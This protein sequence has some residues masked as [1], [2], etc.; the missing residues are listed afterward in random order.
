MT[1][2]KDRL[3][4]LERMGALGWAASINNP[5]PVDQEQSPKLKFISLND[6]AVDDALHFATTAIL[7][8]QSD[9]WEKAYFSG[10]STDDARTAALA[11]IEAQQIAYQLMNIRSANMDGV[12]IQGTPLK[13]EFKTVKEIKD[14]N[15]AGVGTPGFTPYPIADTSVDD[16]PYIILT[17]PPGAKGDKGDQGLQGP[18]GLQGLQGPQG[19]PGVCPD[20]TGGGTGGTGGGPPPP[21]PNGGGT[22]GSGSG[23]GIHT[24]PQ[25]YPGDTS[26]CG[27]PV[28]IYAKD[29]IGLRSWIF[30]PAQLLNTDFDYANVNLRPGIDAVAANTFSDY[31]PANLKSA[32]LLLDMAFLVTE[33]VPTSLTKSQFKD[34]TYTPTNVLPRLYS[35]TT[36]T[37]LLGQWAETSETTLGVEL[38]INGTLHNA[39]LTAG[40]CSFAAITVDLT[41]NKPVYIDGSVVPLPTVAAVI[42]QFLNGRTGAR[43]F[44]SCLV[45]TNPSCAKLPI[46]G[47]WLSSDAPDPFASLGS[48]PDTI[49]GDGQPITNSFDPRAWIR[50]W[51]PPTDGYA[52][53]HLTIKLHAGV[54]AIKIRL[55][56]DANYQTNLSEWGQ[57]GDPNVGAL[58]DI[59]VA[60]G[61]YNA[62][63]GHIML[64]AASCY[65]LEF[66]N[67]N[68][69]RWQPYY[70]DLSWA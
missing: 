59:I 37:N 64:H 42:D 3:S 18:Q 54:A 29:L 23:G 35:D 38:E 50:H 6:A 8:F 62:G 10:S 31:N 5:L 30:A 47:S 57:Y 24:N 51:H 21:P 13:I 66:F 1:G 70:C 16:D 52:D 58:K 61:S 14:L 67:D 44:V 43:I 4:F 22:D 25:G 17:I 33:T 60:P 32:T 34:I 46:R 28:Q 45:Y 53:E 9:E 40:L 39:S 56:D 27:D 69:A 41:G 12:A 63:V 20:C 15:T 11:S 55:R 36:R 65:W 2:K 49:G 7:A 48:N 68:Q 26:I 19:V